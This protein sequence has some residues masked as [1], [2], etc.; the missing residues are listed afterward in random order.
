MFNSN[1]FATAISVGKQTPWGRLPDFRATLILQGHATAT[2]VVQLPKREKPADREILTTGAISVGIQR[3]GASALLAW[4]WSLTGQPDT[5]IF[6]TPFHLGLEDPWDQVLPRNEDYNVPLLVV[7]QD[8]RG[9]CF[10]MRGGV[11]GAEVSEQLLQICQHQLVD[12]QSADFELRHRQT[13]KKMMQHG[14]PHDVYQ[15]A[16]PAPPSRRSRPTLCGANPKTSTT[17]PAQARG[18]LPLSPPSL[19]IRYCGIKQEYPSA[20]SDHASACRHYGAA[21]PR[22][23]QQ[24]H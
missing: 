9:T 5:L 11:I 22:R 18:S 16:L 20:D 10:A 8:S 4:R 14:T 7:A 21:P 15:R 13:I 17:R 6:D 23:C 3:E 2:L 12:A 1:Q 19:P 24:G